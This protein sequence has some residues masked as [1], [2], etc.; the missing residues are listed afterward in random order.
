MTAPMLSTSL[1]AAFILLLPCLGFAARR[2][3][4]YPSHITRALGDVKPD[5]SG[6]LAR[7]IAGPDRG[8]NHSARDHQ[9]DQWPWF[10]DEG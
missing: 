9:S 4:G 6:P 5:F 7:L 1:E 8:R 2:V 3:T 10:T